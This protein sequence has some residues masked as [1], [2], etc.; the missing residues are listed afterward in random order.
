MTENN[1]YDEGE[2]DVMEM[3]ESSEYEYPSDEEEETYAMEDDEAE[4]PSTPNCFQNNHSKKEEMHVSVL[5]E[6]TETA[7]GSSTKKA[8]SSGVGM[9]STDKMII[10]DVEGIR[11]H[12]YNKIIDHVAKL[13]YVSSDEALAL[14]IHFKWNKEKLQEAYFGDMDKLRQTVGIDLYRPYKPASSSNDDGNLVLCGVCYDEVPPSNIVAL[15]CEHPFC[16]DCFRTYLETQVG[17]GP[18]GCLTTKC[19]HFKCTQSVPHSYFRGLLSNAGEK[20]ARLIEKQE[21]YCLRNYIENSRS[22]NFC[23]AA[24]C[25]LIAVATSAA[26]VDE[27][28]KCPCGYRYC[29]KC[30]EEPH[31]PCNCSQLS[32]WNDK[33][34]NESE[35]TNWIIA[36]T[37]KCPKCSVRIEKNQGCNHM[38][39]KHCRHE[40]CWLCFG[41]YVIVF[42]YYPCSYLLLRFVLVLR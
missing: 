31:Q 15:G 33:C 20:S 30:G 2:E 6:E 23:R 25:E 11:S 41:K 17:N 21:A 14:L 3:E 13:L 10:C 5:D 36:N 26:H 22:M 24:H 35:T 9:G 39:C 42:F 40:F 7:G 1:D 38:T 12:Y 4:E 28:V 8:R 34:S 16:S 19:P 27:V 37:K 29:F 32:T 18:P